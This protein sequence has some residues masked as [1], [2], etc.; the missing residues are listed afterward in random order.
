MSFS[1]ASKGG[2]VNPILFTLNGNPAVHNVSSTGENTFFSYIMPGGTLSATGNLFINVLLN[3]FNNTGGNQTITYKLYFGA[4][5]LVQTFALT[6]G[7]S[8]THQIPAQMQ[9][10]ISNSN[11]TNQQYIY[12]QYTQN[13]GSSFGN[14]S[15]DVVSVST[16]LNVTGAN[17]NS[18]DTTQQVQ[19]TLTAQNSAN[20]SSLYTDLY[21]AKIQLL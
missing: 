21:S 15:G 13:N 10:Y 3:T 12:G 11:A 4:G 7:S 20:T 2:G 1:A 19:I 14:V 6:N 17:T 16:S 8:S 5:N 9:L 18:T